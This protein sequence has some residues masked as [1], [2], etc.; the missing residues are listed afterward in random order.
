MTNAKYTTFKEILA[1]VTSVIKTKEIN[2]ADVLEWAVECETEWIQDFPALVPYYKA[3]L[4]VRDKMA[5]V[6]PYC[7]RILDVYTDPDNQK[8]HV[9][10]YNNGA[11]LVLNS[12][13]D[14]KDV[15]VNFMGI[16]IDEETN[17]P[18]IKKGHEEACVQ[19]VLVKLF[20]EDFLTGKLH[21]NTYL[22]MKDERNLQ[23]RAAQADF[24][25]YDRRTLM[26]I[27]AINMNMIPY[28]KYD[29]FVNKT[30]GG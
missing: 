3:K 9:Q 15:Y 5:R 19:H 10:Y 16:A 23:V 1:R 26:E 25:N 4:P 29:S 17:T 7:A 24:S 6:P 11:Y 12:E 27:A 14:K 8:S 28:I 18:M 22:E 13:Y 20:Y 21:P 30:I 2:P